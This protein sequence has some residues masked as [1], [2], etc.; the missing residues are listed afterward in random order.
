MKSS[1]LIVDD[2]PMLRHGLAQLLN[3]EADLEVLGEAGTADEALEALR[4]SRFDLIITDL[5]L[6]GVSGIEL[7]RNIHARDANLPVLVIS[8]YDE[9]VYAERALRAGARGY[10]MKQEATEKVLSAVRRLLAGDVYLSDALQ[11]KMLRRAVGRRGDA[12]VLP[13]EVLSDRELE[14][15]RL[16]GRGRG[17]REISQELHR[18]IKTVEAH[19]ASLKDKLGLKTAAELAHFAAKWFNEG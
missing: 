2:H 11:A 7:V 1:I 15:L 9:T 16:M 10:I 8:M 5:S 6:S 14:V 12:P 18:S 17:T 13:V 3:G 19:R 4:K